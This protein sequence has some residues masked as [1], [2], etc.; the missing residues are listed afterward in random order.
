MLNST[1]I[2]RFITTIVE[3]TGVPANIAIIIPR[4]AENTDNIAEQTVTDLKVL[5]ILIA[6]ISGNITNADISSDPTRFIAKTTITATITA[7]IKLYASVFIPVAF[8]K[9]SSNVTL[10]ILL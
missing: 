10:N 8:A 4:L 7:I 9:L 1:N 5:N 2:N 6:D 3:P